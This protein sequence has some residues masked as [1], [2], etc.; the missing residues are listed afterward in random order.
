MPELTI[1]SSYVHSRVDSSTF[2]LGIGHW[3]TY[4]RVDL[5][6]M[7]ELTLSPSQGLKIVAS[8]DVLY[9]VKFGT[10]TKCSIT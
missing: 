3:A 5:N 9:V 8:E 2:T 4:P 7:P 10:A 6:L 1:T